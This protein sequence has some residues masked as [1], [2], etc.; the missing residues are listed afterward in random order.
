ME[1]R[2]V[3]IEKPA[4]ANLILGQA[5]FI[6]TAEDL[7]EAL[8]CSAPGIRFGLAFCEA[9]GDGLIRAEGTDEALKTL[10]VEN[11]KNI[12]AGHSFVILLG[13]AYPINVLNA[14]KGC[15]EICRIY[16]ATANPCQVVVAETDQGRGILGVID[17][18]APKG[19][20]DDAGAARRK[21]LLRK[22]G[23]KR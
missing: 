15:P 4:E 3:G 17:G 11:A 18:F 5:H 8:V 2:L 9:S 14:V 1:I 12:G 19:V 6:K 22:I 23:Y 7:Y 13:N 20:E 10:A 16:C 21:E